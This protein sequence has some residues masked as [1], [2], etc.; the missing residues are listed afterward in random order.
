MSQFNA[1]D[2][3]YIQKQ[4]RS[5]MLRAASQNDLSS[6]GNGIRFQHCKESFNPNFNR[7]KTQADITGELKE[8]KWMMDNIISKLL[9]K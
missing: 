1:S 4:V 3:K 5:R 2:M 6:V 9:A 8:V 7:C